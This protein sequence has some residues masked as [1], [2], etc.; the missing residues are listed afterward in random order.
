MSDSARRGVFARYWTA[1]TISS[2]GTAVTTVAMPVLV[3]K[4][5]HAEPLEVGLVNA[6]QFLPYAV[7][8]LLAG[9][10]VDRW[11]RKPVLVWSSIGRA[12]ALGA[13][14]VLWAV[15]SL[16]VAGLVLLLLL[17]GAA[18]VFGFA[19]TQSL[20][21]RVVPRELLVHANARLDQT[22]AAAQTLG[23]VL[24]GGLVGLL[25]A[26]LVVAVDALS[27][28]V[29]AALV[30]G[31]RVEESGPRDPGA[32]HLGREIREGLRRTYG[33][34]TLAPLA[35]S[36]HIWFVGNAAGFT[37]LAIIGLRRLDLSA[38]AYGLLIATSAAATLVGAT[39]APMAGHR[40]GSGRTIVWARAA[41]PVAWLLVGVAPTSV[42]G[43]VLLFAALAVHGLA[44]GF[45]N[46]NDMSLWQRLTPDGVLGRTNATRRSANRTC[47]ALGAVAGGAAVGMVGERA[48][49]AVV[50]VVFAA[51]AL[52]AALSPL[53]RMSA[54]PRPA[55]QHPDVQTCIKEDG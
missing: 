37:A 15:G 48:T 18:S 49:V 51:A 23:P 10:Y 29:E 4:G 30:A 1:A 53:R 6:A 24:G 44:T 40:L 34:P 22:D 21:P 36:T 45:E 7:L 5:L 50:V 43:S 52:V 35:A 55:P 31:L 3:V 19:A 13:I 2:F 39:L 11:P 17:F 32:R 27:Y 33:H 25:G 54:T 46:A 42:I 14:P 20:L 41:Y 9:V 12:A 38:A 16:D 8:G 47:G 28:L 26:P